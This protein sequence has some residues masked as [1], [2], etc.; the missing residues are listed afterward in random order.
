[1]GT[2]L[3]TGVT[4]QDGPL[5]SR[6]LLGRG[7]RV[8]G[9]CRGTMPNR[10]S[11]RFCGLDDK[12][13]LRQGD[14]SDLPALIRLLDQLRP[15]EIYN[16]AAQ[17]SVARS[18]DESVSTVS[19]NTQ[20]VINLLE[21]IRI[22]SP[23]SRF[24]QASSSEMFG[25]V[26]SLPVTRRTPMHPVSPYGISKAASH[27]IACHYRETYD[28]FVTCGILFNHESA[29]RPEHFATK[30]ILSAAV[31]IGGG[32]AERLRLGNVNVLRDWGYA[33]EYVE[34]MAGMMARDE[35]EDFII[36]TGTP[37]SLREFA[38]TAFDCVGLD[39]GDHVDIDPSLV[40]RSEIHAI[41]GDPSDAHARLGWRH[42][43]GFRDMI[44]RLLE[45]ERAHQA[46][47][48]AQA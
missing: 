10:L 8:V 39:W 17:S 27:W 34:A 36:C 9:L 18:F 29:L 11:L 47:L 22:A 45:D 37:Y 28:L 13:E 46:F 5:L 2:A 3:V 20:G 19:F 4:G 35:P 32:S 40:R 14:L 6:V 30:K 48:A 24:Y 23:R 26:E 33:P 41:Y 12:I 31:R 42:R 44:A 1:M 25:S 21:A 16:L 7:C 15:D 43:L 38:E